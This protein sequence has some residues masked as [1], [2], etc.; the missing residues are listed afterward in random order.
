MQKKGPPREYVPP[1]KALYAGNRQDANSKEIT[2]QKQL[3]F[4]SH[5]SKSPE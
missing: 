1:T 2:F 5:R 4:Q 3:D